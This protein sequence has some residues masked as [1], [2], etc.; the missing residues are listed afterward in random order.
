VSERNVI[1]ARTAVS[2]EVGIWVQGKGRGMKGRSG[3]RAR[4]G[5]ATAAYLIDLREDFG[6]LLVAS[7]RVDL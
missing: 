7:L 5:K 1:E 4:G 6:G 3:L 2:G